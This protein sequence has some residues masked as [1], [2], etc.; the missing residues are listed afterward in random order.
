[1]VVDGIA[2][3]TAS[4][5]EDAM[6]RGITVRTRTRMGM[7]RTGRTPSRP[8]C[9]ICRMAGATLGKEVPKDRDPDGVSVTT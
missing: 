4:L 6:A 7:D 5:M 3:G 8:I 1:M 2:V 9:W